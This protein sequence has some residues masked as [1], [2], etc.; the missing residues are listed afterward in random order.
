MSEKKDEKK[1]RD[2]A[3]P[4]RPTGI[5][6]I[7]D[8]EDQ[9]ELILVD[10]D[11]GPNGSG[12]R[13][14][15]EGQAV[16]GRRRPAKPRIEHLSFDRFTLAL[17]ASLAQARQRYEAKGERSGRALVLEIREGKI[18]WPLTRRPSRHPD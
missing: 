7:G 9:P 5:W 14:A 4:W 17:S 10:A 2:G 3:F 12:G 6:G 8:R 1:G 13:L 11:P 16:Q 18:P 15:R